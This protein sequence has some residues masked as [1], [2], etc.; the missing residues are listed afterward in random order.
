MELSGCM[1]HAG[2][3]SCLCC[4]AV[5][6]NGLERHRP[7]HRSSGS[8]LVLHF[9]AKQTFKMFTWGY[10]VLTGRGRWQPPAFDQPPGSGRGKFQALL[11]SRKSQIKYLNEHHF[12]G[13]GVGKEEEGGER[14]FGAGANVSGK[15]EM[16]PTPFQVRFY[17]RTYEAGK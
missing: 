1:W 7:P 3:D 14:V 4:E 17:P 6:P 9:L 15:P 8:R 16:F 12:W 2:M 11:C 13:N 10:I 5:C